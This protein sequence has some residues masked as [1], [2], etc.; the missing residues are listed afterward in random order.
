ME[1]AKVST[2]IVLK[3]SLYIF[4]RRKVYELLMTIIQEKNRG[5]GTRLPKPTTRIFLFAHFV[6]LES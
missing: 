1:L 2:G 6:F 4:D 3:D 5:G